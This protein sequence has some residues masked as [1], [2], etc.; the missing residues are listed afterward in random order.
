MQPRAV[1]GCYPTTETE[2]KNAKRAKLGEGV[3]GLNDEAKALLAVL[4]GCFQELEMA[5]FVGDVD[6]RLI[7]SESV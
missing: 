4:C 1:S 6:A 5:R 3:V 7:D 2:L